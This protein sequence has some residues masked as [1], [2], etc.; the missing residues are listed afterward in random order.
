MHL[1]HSIGL[2][3]SGGVGATFSVAATTVGRIR[4]SARQPDRSEECDGFS[5]AKLSGV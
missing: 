5:I 3:A 2:I 1:T 4:N